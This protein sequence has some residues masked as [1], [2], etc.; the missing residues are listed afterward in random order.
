MRGSAATH[1]AL[2][3]DV[4]IPDE[5]DFDAGFAPRASA[6]VLISDARGSTTG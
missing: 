2:W 1:D 4:W 5:R 3:R 6:D